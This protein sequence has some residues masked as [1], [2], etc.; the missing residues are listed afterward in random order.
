[1]SSRIA[2]F[3]II[4]DEEQRVL[5]CHRRDHDLWNLPGG[6]LEAGEAPWQGVIRE[7]QEETGL[8][9]E[10]DRLAGVYSKPEVDQL[11]LSF[12]CT[13]VGGRQMCTEEADRVE[14]FG[15]TSLPRNTIP[16]QAERIH[17]ALGHP[18]RVIM[19]E[20]RGRSALDLL[21]EGTL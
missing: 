10:V 1:M 14:F 21:R 3:A 15:P 17:D 13:V 8:T 9:V 18:D 6:G 11:V 7:V 20:Q 12:V 2:V 19:K 16:K 4:L 5:L